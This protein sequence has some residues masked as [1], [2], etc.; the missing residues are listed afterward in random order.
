MKRETRL[1][2]EIDRFAAGRE[3]THALGLSFGYHGDLA[4][5]RLWT[6]LIEKYGL[7]HPL[8]I[9]DRVIDP[10]T[11]VGVTVLKGARSAGVFHPKLFLAVRE[12]GVLAAVGSA[13]LTSGGLGGN[14]ELLTPLVFAPETE[15]P[16]PPAILRD[17]LAFV[18][19]VADDLKGH[20]DAV[21]VDRILDVIK[22]AELVLDVL[23]EPRRAPSLHFVHSYEAPIWDQLVALHGDDAV[24]HVLVVSPFLER[25]KEGDEPAQGDSDSLLQ[26]AMGDGLPWA[27]RAKKPQLSLYTR[28]INP[29]TPT[30]LPRNAIEALRDRIALQ[31]QALSVES[32]HLHAKMVA[33]F[34][35]KRTTLLWGSPNFTPSALQRSVTDGG[36]VECALVLS[37]A[38][39]AVDSD[40]I[41]E[42][43]ELGAM[44]VPYKDRLPPGFVPPPPPALIFDCGEVLYDPKT[45]TLTASG[46]VYSKKVD[47]IR[48]S[49]KTE[50]DARLLFDD[51]VRPGLFKLTAKDP[52]IEEEDPDTGWPRLRAIVVIVEALDA[53]GTP[54]EKQEMRLNVCFEDAIEVIRGVFLPP[55]VLTPDGML[56]PRSTTPEQRVAELDK[57]IQ[58]AKAARAETKQVPMRHHASLDV[59]FRNVR[60]G[61]DGQWK[62]LEGRRGSRFAL[63][64]WSNTLQRA[65]GAATVEEYEGLRRTYLVARVSEHINQVIDAVPDWHDELEPAFGAIEADKLADVLAAVRIDDGIQQDFLQQVQSA[66]NTTVGS[67][68]RIGAGDFPMAKQ[69]DET[70]TSTRR[71]RRN[72]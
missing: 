29:Q 25:D 58:R 71:G 8:V 13:N 4:S 66:Q 2:D 46:E 19:R 41:L 22:Q 37:T 7:R 61:L 38:A 3:I 24:Q 47:R 21:S 32:R 34:G 40:G 48:G 63:R 20:A 45:K 12:D 16:I 30:L 68:R 64:Y 72:A 17:I 57:A 44:F 9:T 49:L 54:L 69:T 27:A 14:L 35:K 43:F 55:E 26:Y 62:T 70:Q 15:R 59:F 28:A 60:L 51:T 67:L 1:F 52:G 56:M 65:L 50:N 18:K 5:E 23:P 36:N 31:A 53:E 6:P 11:N 42:D 10:G 33:I 39:N